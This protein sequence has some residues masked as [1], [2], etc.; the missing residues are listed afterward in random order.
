MLRKAIVGVIATALLGLGVDAA[1]AGVGDQ[2][3][4]SQPGC[5]TAVLMTQCALH[6]A[7]GVYSH[8]AIPTLYPLP[9]LRAANGTLT[10]INN[11]HLCGNPQN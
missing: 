9:H 6:G 10:G 4:C 8:A 2:G 3:Y 7:F 1:L 5:K 11:S